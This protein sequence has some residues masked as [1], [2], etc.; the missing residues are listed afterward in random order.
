M[1]LRKFFSRN[2]KIL[3]LNQV[4]EFTSLAPVFRS[5]V[6]TKVGCY[7]MVESPICVIYEVLT[8][9]DTFYCTYINYDRNVNIRSFL[10]VGTV[11]LEIYKSLWI[12]VV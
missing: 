10:W 11:L 4:F 7:Y 9:T 8:S 6:K 3:Y 5:C 12:L 1:Y 2:P